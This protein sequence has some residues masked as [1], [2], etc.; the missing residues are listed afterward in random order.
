MYLSFACISAPLFPSPPPS[1]RLY[2]VN[3]KVF[4]CVQ[5]DDDAPAGELGRGEA[6]SADLPSHFLLS[7]VVCFQGTRS[8]R[9]PTPAAVNASA[10]VL[11]VLEAPPTRHWIRKEECESDD[12]FPHPHPHRDEGTGTEGKRTEKTGREK[13]KVFKDGREDAGVKDPTARS[14][15]ST[16]SIL[17]ATSRHLQCSQFM[18]IRP[19][20]RSASPRWLS[21]HSA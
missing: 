19:L 14:V 11:A 13:K 4:L 18:R 10:R 16:S 21:H 3:S 15:S 1:C 6:V 9:P 20:I 2:I 12:C 8:D 7:S 5:C 17:P